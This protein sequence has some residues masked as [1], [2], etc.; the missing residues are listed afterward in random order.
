M[1]PF[2]LCA[3]L[4]LGCG[5]A[6]EVAEASCPEKEVDEASLLQTPGIDAGKRVQQ[7]IKH[8]QQEVHAHVASHDSGVAEK[9]APNAEL[10][11]SEYPLRKKADKV[12]QLLKTDDAS[13]TSEETEDQAEVVYQYLLPPDQFPEM[14]KMV[15][16]ILSAI[17]LG[18]CGVDRCFF[19][20]TL[21]IVLGIAKGV[22]LGGFGIWFLVD[23][24]IIF[25]NCVAKWEKMDVL[26]FQANFGDKELTTAFWIA[27]AGLVLHCCCGGGGSAYKVNSSRNGTKADAPQSS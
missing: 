23:Y 2:L 25:V 14:N 3:A 5:Q 18:F 24:A 4:L 6:Q 16:A 12:A 21:N 19:G 27:I 20:N 15:L 26:G 9:Q 22:T 11:M 7:E 10:A 1:S 17:G 8:A 13:A